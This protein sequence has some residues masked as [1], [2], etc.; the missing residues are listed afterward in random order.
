[1]EFKRYSAA[2]LANQTET[3]IAVTQTQHTLYSLL[4][5]ATLHVVL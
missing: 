3:A 2:I 5:Q 4:G 1:M